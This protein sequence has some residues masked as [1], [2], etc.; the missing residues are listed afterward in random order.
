MGPFVVRFKFHYKTPLLQK[1]FLTQVLQQSL[2]P[3]LFIL[4]QQTHL[5][6]TLPIF[7]T[8]PPHISCLV[9]MHA[10]MKMHQVH[11][12]ITFQH[13]TSKFSSQGTQ[14]ITQNTTFFIL[15]FWHIFA[16][17]WLA[18]ISIRFPRA[19]SL[20]FSFSCLAFCHLLHAS[21]YLHTLLNLLFSPIA[22]LSVKN[23]FLY[24]LTTSFQS[25]LHLH[26]LHHRST[27]Q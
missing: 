18:L 1:H 13:K 20:D 17:W 26:I 7:H 16:S 23:N 19:C 27:T 8:H 5:D 24:S 10:C 4:P 2:T 9:L 22:S 14:Q 11:K 12:Y 3:S 15:S 6:P 25:I 21:D